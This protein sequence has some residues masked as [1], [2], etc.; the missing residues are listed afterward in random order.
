[1][2]M[3]V[4]CVLCLPVG[5]FKSWECFT[6]ELE[7]RGFSATRWRFGRGPMDVG[8][9]AKGCGLALARGAGHVVKDSGEFFESFYRSGW[10]SSVRVVP[11]TAST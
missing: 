1:M 7:T 8:W 10:S 9:L 3:W 2:A 4:S 6:E 11:Y 5:L